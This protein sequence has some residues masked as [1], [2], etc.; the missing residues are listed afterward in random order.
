MSV[1]QEQRIKAEKEIMEI[2]H[3]IEEER[4]K[5]RTEYPER[6]GLDCCSG[7]LRKVTEEGFQKIRKIKEKYPDCGDFT[8]NQFI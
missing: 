3:W 6:V 7:E 4:G 1:D 5:I 2:L 8:L